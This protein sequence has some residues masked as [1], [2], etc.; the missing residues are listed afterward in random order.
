MGMRNVRVLQG[1]GENWRDDGAQCPKMH[2][3]HFQDILAVMV[4]NPWF[5]NEEGE[6]QHDFIACSTLHSKRCTKI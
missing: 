4:I 3:L 2:M 6:L 5:K 1:P